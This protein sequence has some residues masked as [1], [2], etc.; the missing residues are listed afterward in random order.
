MLVENFIAENLEVK[1]ARDVME[2]GGKFGYL[3]IDFA[4]IRATGD[5]NARPHS[6]TQKSSRR[7]VSLARAA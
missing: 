4:R 3:E 5:I 6:I 7:A 1:A 2:L